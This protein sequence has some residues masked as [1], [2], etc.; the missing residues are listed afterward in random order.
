MPLF[1]SQDLS[2]LMSYA[3]AG[4]ENAAM[5]AFING[6]ECTASSAQQAIDSAK[7]EVGN[8]QKWKLHAQRQVVP[9]VLPH[10]LAINFSIHLCVGF[11]FM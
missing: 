5:A 7:V 3:Y 2:I 1:F 6:I 4:L 10:F 11:F 8:Y 9:Q